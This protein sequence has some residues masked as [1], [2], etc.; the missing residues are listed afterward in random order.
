MPANVPKVG[1]HLL[2][3][4]DQNPR[5]ISVWDKVA[6]EVVP[7]CLQGKRHRHDG[8]R[9]FVRPRVASVRI[10]D[11]ADGI[12]EAFCGPA[13]S[14]RR[15]RR[16]HT[17]ERRNAHGRRHVGHLLLHL[18]GTVRRDGLSRG[19]IGRYVGDV[20]VGEGGTLEGVVQQAEL[21]HHIERNQA[22]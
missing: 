9:D 10:L 12:R 3:H 21:G 16:S 15:R 7:G 8:E 4:G 22:G 13:P 1:D 18:Q 19:S 20:V 5:A 17:R 6:S 11:S 2:L 14:V